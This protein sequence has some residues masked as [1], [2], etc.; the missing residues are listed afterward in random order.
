V[1]GAQKFLAMA[2]MKIITTNFR[3]RNQKGRNNIRRKLWFNPRG[4][5]EKLSSMNLALDDKITQTKEVEQWC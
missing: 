5:G 4:T 3:F 2:E 1:S